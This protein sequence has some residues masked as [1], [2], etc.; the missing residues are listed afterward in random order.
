VVY[1][2]VQRH[3]GTIDVDSAVGRGTTFRITLSRRPVP[4]PAAVEG[5]GT[6]AHA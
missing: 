1:G 4:A 6:P 3:G 5:P 2:I